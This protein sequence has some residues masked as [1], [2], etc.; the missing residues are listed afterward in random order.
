MLERAR[1]RRASETPTIDA[2]R[3][4][5]RG[6]T[7]TEAEEAVLN[8]PANVA[9][10]DGTGGRIRARESAREADERCFSSS[11]SI[12]KDVV[13]CCTLVGI[14]ACAK[15]RRRNVGARRASGI[16]P[17]QLST[18]TD[19]DADLWRT[20]LRARSRPSGATTTSNAGR[21]GAGCP[22]PRAPWGSSRRISPGTRR[23]SSWRRCVDADERIRRPP[24]DSSRSLPADVDPRPRESFPGAFGGF[25]DATGARGERRGEVPLRGGSPSARS[26]SA[27][28]VAPD[29][30]LRAPAPSRSRLP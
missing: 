30:V 14:N 3:A 5:R 6:G 24:G 27:R 15:R 17:R 16:L 18:E 9:G 7:L 23:T 2:M 11:A 20:D 1:R 21:P 29:A 13:P 10:D 22:R 12:L 28:G 19:G 26:P 25:P 4:D 8:I